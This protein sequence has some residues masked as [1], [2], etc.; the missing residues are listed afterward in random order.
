MPYGPRT[1]LIRG[2]HL[3][4]ILQEK[5]IFI[6]NVSRL[7]LGYFET[8][9]RHFWRLAKFEGY[10]FWGYNLGFSRN[11]HR[12]PFT[13]GSTP[14]PPP[15]PGIQPYQTTDLK[16]LHHIGFVGY[17]DIKSKS[18]CR[19]ITT[20]GLIEIS[21][22]VVQLATLSSWSCTEWSEIT[23]GEPLEKW[24]GRRIF[25]LQE[26]FSLNAFL[27]TWPCMNLHKLSEPV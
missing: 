6:C 12:R 1:W 18:E 17:K 16:N 23:R 27:V 4:C 25:S 11:E 8:T 9:M 7:F 15:S 19:A 24:W 5:I 3:I 2:M 22:V 21:R 14:S 26:F 10:V 20:T 13:I